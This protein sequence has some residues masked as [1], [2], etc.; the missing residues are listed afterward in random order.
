VALSDHFEAPISVL[1][2][3][4]IIVG[5]L[6]AETLLALVTKCHGASV[7]AASGQTEVGRLS[8]FVVRALPVLVAAA[9]VLVRSWA[10]DGLALVDEQGWAE[11]RRAWTIAV[12]TARK[13]KGTVEGFTVRSL[14]LRHQN[15]QILSRLAGYAMANSL[16]YRGSR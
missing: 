9:A 15:G 14:R 12:I 1:L 6:L 4:D 11:F 3:L 5:L 10:V 16:K 7:I 13:A 8:P 2:T